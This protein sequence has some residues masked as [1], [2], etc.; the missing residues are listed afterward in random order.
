MTWVGFL[1]AGLRLGTVGF[2]GGLAVLSL[3]RREFVERRRLLSDAEFAEVAAMSQ[4]LPGA[5]SVNAF[6]ILGTRLGGWWCGLVA[7]WAFIWPS[8]LMMLA[9]A[10]TYPAFRYLPMMDAALVGMSAAVVAL[11]VVTAVSLARAGAIRQ[12]LD[13]ILAA[14]AFVLVALNCIGVLEAVLLAGLVG[15]L[16]RAPKLGP[17]A[18]AVFPPWLVM[19]LIR[20]ASLSGF[21]ALAAVFLR[22]GAATFGGG[23]VM[24]PFIEQ[25]V[26]LHHAWLTPRE[27]ADAV[28]LGQITPGPVVISATFIG[29]RVAGLLGSVVATGMVFLPPGLLAIAAGH[30]LERFSQNQVVAGFLAGV[31]PAVVGLLGSAAVSLGR[32]GL[33]NPG[34]WV[35]A[36]AALLVLLRWK[37][38]PVLVLVASALVYS[39]GVRLSP[40]LF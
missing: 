22:I 27:F 32:S 35:L 28:A 12:R 1:L 10:A 3:I 40:L 34:A 14:A 11:V 18:G 7:G 20:G 24:I 21:F 36:L 33:P 31:R 15:I 4:A 26:V 23:F 6:T 38:H 17:S 30:A 29:Y 8:F 5:V 13:A 16:A 25:E 2:G 9:F 19:I 37:P 39:A